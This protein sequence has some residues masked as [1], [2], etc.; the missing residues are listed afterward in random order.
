M[1]LAHLIQQR[2]A[3]E[4][5]RV[6]YT[7]LADGGADVRSLTWAQLHARAGSVAA[8][9]LSR[10]AAKRPVLLALP[11]SLDFVETLFGCWY[12]GAIAVPISLPRHQR[13]KHRLDRVIADSGARFAIGNEDSQKRIDPTG[14]IT[15]LDC[16][17]SND[18]SDSRADLSD[19][20]VL[21]YTSGSTGSP[22]GVMIT[23]ANLIA[24]S[25]QIA[26]ACQH[27]ASKT[28][29]GWVPLYHDMGLVGLIQAAFTGA[30]CIFM[31]PERFL[32]RPWSWLQ[33]IS[34]YKVWSSP[35]PNFAYDLCVDRVSEEQKRTLD[36]SC[37]RNALNGS[38]PVRGATLQRFANAFASCGFRANSF[39]PCYGMAE[40]TLFV[41][42]PGPDRIA[43]RRS[44]DGAKLPDGSPDGHVG[45]G[46]TFGDT[47]LAIV[48]PEAVCRVA[49]GAIG[50][51]WISGESCARGYWNSPDA[52]AAAF[53]ARLSDASA[54][55]A[56]TPWLRTGDLGMIAD[57]Q[58]FITGRL[59]EL[60][61]IAGRNLFPVDIERTVESA[62]AAIAPFG[63]AA[64]SI[65]RGGAESLVVL[66]EIRRELARPSRGESRSPFDPR[67][68]GRKIRTAV[69]AEHDV[70]PRE[71][72]LLAPGTLPR[73]TSGKLSRL[74]ARDEYLNKTLELLQ[75]H[76]HV[77]I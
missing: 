35:A 34:D 21:Q 49:D 54:E 22:R 36:L 12:A 46:Y 18:F 52:T 41:T 74:T 48:D 44:A 66:A 24:N 13:V 39:F 7:F 38:E 3:R 5:D 6:G 31:Q 65:D 69:A 16:L 14:S 1:T 75:T 77:A 68:I 23:H 32:M 43:A 40:T 2:A 30:R 62:D 76:V 19:L 55:D 29:A 10:G 64:F 50:E 73:T 33:M 28:I 58:L 20:A 11:S 59:K 37:W 45:C 56:E 15:W 71:I 8:N 57:G 4:A 17:N 70:T 27:D 53:D 72:L 61:I 26:D 63:A 67:A 51:I 42:G 25:R 47:R 60:I 9:L